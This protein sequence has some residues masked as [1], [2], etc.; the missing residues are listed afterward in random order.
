MASTFFGLNIGKTGLYAYKAALNVTAHNIANAETEGY[1]RQ[2][3]GIQAGKPLRMNSTYG[4]AGTGVTVTGVNQLRDEYYDLKFR[5]NNTIFGEYAAKSHYMTEIENYFNEVT[6]EGF[7]TSFDSLYKSLQELSN[8]PSSLTARTQVINYGKSLTEYFNS[9]STNLKKIQEECNF[10]IRNMVEKINSIAQ[11]IASLTKQINTLEVSGGK[12]NDLRD[13][14]NLLVDELSQIAN[15][16]VTEKV[17]GDGIGVTSYVIKIDGQTLVDTAEYNKLKVVPR[18]YK[19]N[20][21]DID[22]LYDV[23]WEN[24]QEFNLGSPNIGGALKGLYE[25]RDGNNLHNLQGKVTAAAG[26]IFIVVTGTTINAVEKLNI[27]ETG[28]IKLGNQEYAYAGFEVKIDE[29]TGE[30]IYTFE[31]KEPLKSQFVDATAS[32][33]ES[34]NYKGI[35]Y[36]LDQMNEFIRTFSKAFNDIHRAGRDLDNDAGMDFFTATNKVSGR[37]YVFGP[38]AD[39]DDYYYDYSTFNSQTGSFYEDVPSNQPLYGSYY[40][41]TAENFTINSMLINNPRNFAAST[42]VLNGIDNND[43]V[44]KLIRL[45]DDKSMF[46]TGTPAGFMQTLVADIGIDTRKANNFTQSQENILKAISNH[47]L[48]I[49]GV[50]IDEEA[51][52]LVRF[53]NAYN[54]SAKVVSVMNEIYDKLINYMGV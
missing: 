23:Y 16:T 29:T 8:N 28:I 36:Y 49:S 25:L 5:K 42:D 52:N 38:Y 31:L 3:M 18:E 11:Q 40:F 20:Q 10:E 47:K 50:D 17:V 39:S 54:L 53:Q 26:E 6:L 46:G 45:K 51:M 19:Q 35:S 32:I 4:M 44:E 37:E 15:I 12:A 43:I 33:G 41:M 30:F 27:P 9:L 21:N 22:G 34:I 1:S 2:V 13:Q 48:S 7:T 24:G 14:R